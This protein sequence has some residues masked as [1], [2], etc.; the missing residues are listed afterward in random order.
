[1]K[2]LHL[3][4]AVRGK[5]VRTIIPDE[6]TDR[7]SDLV[8]RQFKANHP[9]QLWVSD[10]TYVSTWQAWLYVAFV[11]DVYA[12]Y[13]V[14]WRVSRPMTSDFVLDAL[15]QALC[16]A[17]RQRWSLIHHSDRGT[18]YISI[19]IQSVW[20]WMLLH[21]QWAAR[22]MATITPLLKPSMDPTRQT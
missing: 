12:R 5:K 9:N 16:K 10:F 2:R 8:N 15:E 1:M 21:L 20:P 22:G 3:R 4:G 18:Q 13:I 17:T 7:P 14:G 19:A 11:I 6:L